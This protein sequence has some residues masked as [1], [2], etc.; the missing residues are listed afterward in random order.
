MSDSANGDRGKDEQTDGLKLYQIVVLLLFV[1]GLFYLRYPPVPEGAQSTVV[2]AATAIR[3]GQ[4]SE[5]H[6]HE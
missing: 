6:R 5:V 1:A 4:P 3:P 2:T